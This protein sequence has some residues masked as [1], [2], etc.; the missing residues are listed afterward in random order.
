MLLVLAATLSAIACSGGDGAT[1]PEGPSGP[2]GPVGPQGNANVEIYEFGPRTF[3]GSLNL[4]LN[5][6]R[7]KIDSSIVSV[8][9]NP[10]L[11][12]A[13]A[14][15]PMPGQGSGGS[16]ETRFF[17][18]QS[19]TAPTSVYTFGIRTVLPTG[20]PYATQVT[21]SKIRIVL[22]RASSITA[23]PHKAPPNFQDY[24]SIKRYFGLP[25]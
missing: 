8:Y 19:A 15:Y 1:G 13:T 7:A 14:W 3:T 21:F 16:Y 22:T 2:Q 4:T 10:A 12:S 6:T 24:N 5:V 9:Y 11:E 20:G 18:H 25:N 23:T 17:L